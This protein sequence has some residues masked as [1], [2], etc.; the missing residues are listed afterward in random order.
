MSAQLKMVGGSSAPLA[1][2]TVGRSWS[3]DTLLDRARSGL[4]LLVDLAHVGQGDDP[5]A[6]DIDSLLRAQS[7][8]VQ[9]LTMIELAAGPRL[10]L[11]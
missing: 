9:A 10:R 8:V 5:D 6:D 2:P 1:E 11:L 3:L 4:Q 7:D